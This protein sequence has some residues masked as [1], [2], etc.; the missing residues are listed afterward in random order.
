M[1]ELLTNKNAIIYGAGGSIGGA[2]ARTFARE[3][4]TVFLA[5]RTRETLERVAGGPIEAGP[6]IRYLK[7]KLGQVYGLQ[8][9]VP[10]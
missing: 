1:N 10:S 9:P 5:G 2:V 4:A 8:A 6:Y 3:G 7:D